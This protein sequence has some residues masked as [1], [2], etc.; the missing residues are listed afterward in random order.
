M[1]RGGASETMHLTSARSVESA[2]C[3][4]ACVRIRSAAP[5]AIAFHCHLCSTD[6]S[7]LLIECVLDDGR[8]A[9]VDSDVTTGRQRQ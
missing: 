2:K 3:P 6:H 1:Q 4:H 5:I 7:R 9:E 8:I